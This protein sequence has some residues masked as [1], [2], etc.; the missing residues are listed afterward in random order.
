MSIFDPDSFLNQTV[1]SDF[2]T[3]RRDVPEGDYKG[4]VKKV[5]P[6]EVNTKN[7][8][9]YQLALI[10]V[11][12]DESARMATGLDE[13]TVQQKVWLDLDE[14]GN[15]KSGPNANVQLGRIR[16]AVGQNKAGKKWSIPMLEGA[17][18]TIHV[19]TRTVNEDRD[20]NPLDEPMVFTEVSRV[21]KP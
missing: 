13:P 3:R 11:V 2:E 9:K 12:D 4:Y 18:A 19:G 16:A 17:A 6:V 5:T 21:A 14:N 20:G 15:L 1:D 7:G 10:W 8:T